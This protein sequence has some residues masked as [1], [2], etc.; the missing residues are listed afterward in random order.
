MAKTNEMTAVLEELKH[1]GESLICIADRLSDYLNIDTEE[2]EKPAKTKRTKKAA[3][4]VPE[5]MPEE[6][7]EE[8]EK[9]ISLAEVRAVLAEKSREGYTDEVKDLIAKH[10]AQ[11]LS[12]IA[13]ENYAALLA[14]AEVLGDD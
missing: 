2:P 7:Q 14:D 11:K 12:D 13:P 3:E 8:L 4:S 6:K 5:E 10:G 1:C 9:K